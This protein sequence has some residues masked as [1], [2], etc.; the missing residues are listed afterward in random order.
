MKDRAAREPRTLL[1]IFQEEQTE[2]ARAVAD[3]DVVA[4]NLPQF[5]TIAS[6]L[7]KRRNK[8]FLTLPK[9]VSELTID[10]DYKL[11]EVGNRFLLSQTKIK[12]GSN[13]EHVL[14]FCSD[15]GLKVLAESKRWHADG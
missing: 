15:V 2:Y 14:I 6:G 11:T 7:Y 1:Q 12:N 3:V 9:L 13:D 8:K 10:G 5:E 4:Q